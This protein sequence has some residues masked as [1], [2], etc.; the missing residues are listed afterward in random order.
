[1]LSPTGREGWRARLRWQAPTLWE[2]SVLAS[3]H[4]G[5]R[6]AV[7]VILIGGLGV[8]A[9]RL[10]RRLGPSREE[11]WRALLARVGFS[12]HAAWRTGLNHFVRAANQ[13]QEENGGDG[14][15]P[16][17]QQTR[18][19][20]LLPP[21][22]LRILGEAVETAAVLD[23]EGARSAGRALDEL[24]RIHRSPVSAPDRLAEA[25]RTLVSSFGLMQRALAERFSC[26][27]QPV[28]ERV[29]RFRSR[30]GAASRI[31][32]GGGPP[33][34]TRRF[35]MGAE[36]LFACM[37]ELIVNAGKKDP[38]PIRIGVSVRARGGKV[39]VLEVHD[40]GPSLEAERGRS[41]REGTRT[42][43]P[44]IEDLLRPY[45]GRLV[46]EDA[47]GGGVLARILVPRF[48]LD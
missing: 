35:P 39:A 30:G 19:R 8:L 7:A 3:R 38:A 37:D 5:I 31:E 27:P 2:Y 14:P 1:V 41:N 10:R 15:L 28:F 40:D 9:V 34:L 36:D 44:R 46:L 33:D 17:D 26:R 23:V 43:V 21:E 25:G 20:G 4:P 45:G 47:E 16:E 12:S 22:L 18:L 11:R 6:A 29:R 48:D 42:G 32:W 24:D 13:I